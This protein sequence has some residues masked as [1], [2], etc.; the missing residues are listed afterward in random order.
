MSRVQLLPWCDESKDMND[1]Y[2]TLK[3]K[4]GTGKGTTLLPKNEDLVSLQ[5][6]DG[7]P[8]TRIL[9]KGVAGSGKSTM[10]AKLAY[11]W[12]QQKSDSPLAKYQLLFILS[13]R[14]VKSG[15]LIDEI[16]EQIFETKT[17]VS[18][19]GLEAY[20]ESNPE[21]CLLLLD[22]FDEYSAS[23][24]SS[25]FGSLQEIIVFKNLRECCTI[26]STRPHKDLQ[27]HQSSY[28]LVDVLGF[29]HK[30]VEL[31]MNRFFS[32]N[33][34][35]VQG[36]KERINE[37]E[38]LTSLSTTPVI[39][40]LV[41]LLWEDEQKLPDTQSELYQDFVLFLWRKYC[42]R[43]GKDIDFKDQIKGEFAEVITG[44]GC[45]ALEGLCS[46]DN[47][48]E[49]KIIFAENDFD[50]SLYQVGCE[51]GLLTR[52][53]IR[54][55]LSI[56][57]AVTFLHKSFQEFCAAKYWVSLYIA[58]RD[59]FNSTLIQ[60]RTWNIFMSKFDLVKFCCGLAEKGG[61]VSI[62]Q[63]VI[64]LYKVKQRA[65]H[66]IC[67]GYDK[68][69]SGKKSIVNILT[70]L[71]E[72]QNTLLDPSQKETVKN[73]QS[74]KSDV[75]NATLI[76]SFKSIFPDDGFILNVGDKYPKAKSTFLNFVKS[77][78]GSSI[79]STVKSI[80]IV[81]PY[82]SQSVYADTLRCMS[83][84]EKLE[85]SFKEFDKQSKQYFDH[86][87]KAVGALQKLCKLKLSY[88]NGV[89][90]EWLS[91]LKEIDL[92]GNTVGTATALLFQQM[93]KC[94]SKCIEQR[95]D[96]QITP[97]NDIQ[98]NVIEQ[99]SLEYISDGGE[100][101]THSQEH[102][103]V[104]RKFGVNLRGCS[105][106]DELEN[107]IF[108]HI[109]NQNI[110]VIHIDNVKIEENMIKTLSE[111]LFK[112]FKLTELNLINIE[113]K[114]DQSGMLNSG[115]TKKRN[116]IEKLSLKDLANKEH[117]STN[118]HEQTTV[119][120]KFDFNIISSSLSDVM[121]HTLFSYFINRH[122][123][124]I[125][126]SIG[127]TLITLIE[128]LPEATNLQKLDLSGNSYYVRGLGMAIGSLVQQLQHSTQFNSLKL[129][130]KRMKKDH[131]KTLSKFLPKIPNLQELD[132]SENTVGEAIA[133][134]LEQLQHCTKLI[135]LNLSEAG[136][137]KDHIQQLSKF[138]PKV[139]NLQNLNLSMNA[140]GMAILPLVEQLQ[141]FTNLI[142]LD[143]QQAKLKE[144]H[145]KILSEFLP[146]ASK[147]QE[148]YLSENT[149]GMVIVPLVQQLQHC[150]MLS[151]L[152][153]SVA[154]ITDQGVIKLCHMFVSMPN[155]TSLYL[156]GNN[157]GNTGVD[158]LF[159]HI[160]HLTK[161]DYLAIDAN[162]N[163]QCS[164]LVKDCLVAIRKCGNFGY[165][166]CNPYSETNEILV[167]QSMDR[168]D[169]QLVQR[170]ASIHLE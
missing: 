169:C 78:L 141:Y 87:E 62:I 165:D 20:I 124:V 155:L 19:D 41:C 2:V 97:E 55:R 159:R 81:N 11:T 166:P 103:N 145:I 79:F 88:S 118:Y 114:E 61:M 34:E 5:K 136:L 154:H 28:L 153:L 16:F 12:S 40:M 164:T 13:L 160:H 21:L 18:K 7:M 135:S 30:N 128:F 26:L 27:S 86:L 89:Q 23:D 24:L 64:K 150:P 116:M 70:L 35:M 39:L 101:S 96:N 148:L 146:K 72:C 113:I 109:I 161:L 168:A 25:P 90:I 125:A 48:I 134:L 104:L 3:L 44:L 37:S 92:S 65:K 117:N 52:E 127:F 121:L 32:G 123:Q 10:L 140:I 157:I 151:A 17:T 163:N 85:L 102:S 132:L 143:L 139:P 142:T 69:E 77:E 107:A 80:T 94:C 156:S 147:L 4:K 95:K 138:L 83:N 66:E 82:Q 120:R 105:Q 133:P 31:Y 68:P 112:S 73:H 60:M 76:Q 53:R 49:E 144:D 75:L 22:G 47:I 115:D 9:V 6:S 59:K 8:A 67:I 33:K 29:S 45:L 42:M 56:N 93:L 50:K 1:I 111:Y 122:I 152:D 43:Q 170:T 149:I 110:Q 167:S 46:K 38:K 15:S 131:I 71:F 129:A 99:L 54:S 36:L 162:I 74:T 58:N 130:R 91:L 126:M 63:Y 51:T 57:S 119:L 14:E 100:S 106:T 108:T 158:A 84:V 98:P 137:K